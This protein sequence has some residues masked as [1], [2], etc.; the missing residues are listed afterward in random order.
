[1]LKITFSFTKTFPDVDEYC[2]EEDIDETIKEL[3]S[4]LR[5]KVLYMSQELIGGS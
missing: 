4:L 3:E 5:S 1:M 2:S